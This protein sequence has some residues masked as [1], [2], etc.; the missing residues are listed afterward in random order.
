MTE[1]QRQKAVQ[2]FDTAGAAP[3][4]RCRSG[5]RASR[6]RRSQRYRQWRPGHER[7]RAMRLHRVGLA[8]RGGEVTPCR[9]Y[10][11]INPPA[12]PLNAPCGASVVLDLKIRW[13]HGDLFVRHV[14]AALMRPVLASNSGLIM[15]SK[16]P[17]V[18]PGNRSDKGTA[19]RSSATSIDKSVKH[20]HHP[21]SAEE[22]ETANIKQNTT[23]NGFF[24]GRRFEK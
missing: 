7:R 22:G 19:N 2:R 15:T 6:G 11:N 23:N 13:K 3:D 18:P 14:E 5:D 16:M 21:N 4:P 10:L 12:G 17:P 1:Y 24:R 9:V 8:P 20:E